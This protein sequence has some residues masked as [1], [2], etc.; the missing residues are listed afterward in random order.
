MKTDNRETP[1]NFLK[2]WYETAKP[3]S[4]EMELSYTR[5]MKRMKS[6]LERFGETVEEKPSIS[7]AAYENNENTPRKR[8]RR[9]PRAFTPSPSPKKTQ[10]SPKK[11][12]KTPKMRK[13][14]C[15]ST[16]DEEDDNSLEVHAKNEYIQVMEN[17]RNRTAVPEKKRKSGESN[18][19]AH[20]EYDDWL[21]DDLGVNVKKR[22]SCG[23]VPAD[24]LYSSNARSPV[25][26]TKEGTVDSDAESRGSGASED[27]E[28]F[29]NDTGVKPASR[30]KKQI[31]LIK[32]GF[33][34][35]KT[36]KPDLL[37]AEREVQSSVTS[38]VPS[39]SVVMPEVQQPSMFAVDVRIEEKLYRVPIPSSEVN[40]HTIRWL[41]DEASKRY[42]K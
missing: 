38:A 19:T 7:T 18:K 4:E 42:F 17:L 26:K 34:R 35:S 13:R 39:R 40:V 23:Q 15:D 37:R 21:E 16:T 28:A 6:A 8:W 29:S 33:S 10:T 20:V 36:T 30:R 24:L 22:K 5:I 11:V 41:A 2:Q 3:L 27:G 14:L 31:S 32:A 1:L 9:S 25:N 12:P